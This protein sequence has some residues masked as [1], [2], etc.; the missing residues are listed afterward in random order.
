MTGP[1]R[2]TARARL[3]LDSRRPLRLDGR[4]QIFL[5][6]SGVVDVFARTSG[7]GR[8]HLFRVADGE[9]LLG[10]P[11][12]DAL[13]VLGVGSQTGKVQV[14]DRAQFDDAGS[15][16]VWLRRLQA[17]A[18]GQPAPAIDRDLASDAAWRAVDRA[19]A[20]AMSRIHERLAR[21]DARENER[22]RRRADAATDQNQRLFA[23]LARIIAPER[24][25]GVADTVSGDLLFG[26]CRIVGEAL[27]VVMAPAGGDTDFRGVAEIARASRVRVRKTLLRSGWRDQDVGPLVAW[28]G[29]ERRPV[30]ILPTARGCDLVDPAN[31][32]RQPIDDA[33][34]LN[35]SAE[36]AAFYRPLPAGPLSGIGLML[37]TAAPIR[38]DLIR[39]P[40]AAMGLALLA[41]GPPLVTAVLVDEAIPRADVGALVFCA[42]A[43][44]AAAIGA[45][46]FQAIQGVAILRLST[47]ADRMLQAA[48]IDR[49][50]R[51]PASF[52]KRF[53]AGDLTDRVL[54]VDEIRRMLTGRA[55]GGLLAGIFCLFGIALMFVFEARLAAVAAGLILVQGAVI[56]AVSARRLRLERRYFDLHG[57]THGL[58]LQIL[59]GVGKLRVADAITR[60]L[61]NWVR[62]F[63][64][65][66]TQFIAS[67]RA[68]NGLA[69]FEATYP[70]AA[71]LTVFALAGPGGEHGADPGRFLAFFAAFGQ[72]LSAMAALGAAV[73]ETLMAAPVFDRLR[74]ILAEPVEASEGLET[75]GEIRGEVELVHV[76]FRYAQTGA[77]ILDRMALHVNAGE[78]VALVGPSGGGKSTI[79]RLLLGF[80]R[81]HSGAIL[82]DGRPIDTLD[83]SALRRQIGVV[84][85]DGK[86]TSGSLYENI[87]GASEIPIEQAWEAARHAGL[88]A[89]IE[90]MPMG[91]HTVVT[92]GASTLSGGQRQRLMIA[93][94]LVHRPRLLLFDEATSALDNRLQ[95]VVSASIAGLK[96]TRIVIAHRLSTVRSAD[97]I[98]VVAAG[99]VVQAGDY[100]SLRQEPGLFADLARRQLV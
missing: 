4:T 44:A 32:M 31:G 51:L 58:V 23:R 94:A 67:Q 78:F 56:V 33:M 65:Q 86:L 26:A 36:A 89:D 27:G 61:A 70:I 8:T 50:L 64:A 76:T 12:I 77:P 54:G 34:A 73:G 81:A 99:A 25:S 75:L 6:L 22:L 46:A 66:K 28:L 3:D 92:E 83:L 79:L 14:I 100:E 24:T 45:A 52:F 40:M 49:L 15:V 98:Y 18:G 7:A 29:E 5:V 62:L 93:R 11:A 41:L 21:A 48:V 74:P 95:A 53:S 1:A 85:Q 20:A 17:A 19:Q 43:L 59:T 72:A 68:A 13:E 60:A 16:E 39:V 84:L 38:A 80:E 97:R 88:A 91:M 10:L 55:I 87:C 37:W 82:I 96:V 69:V 90:A 47:A 63:A 9:I 42:L 30:A 71:S 35:L 57:K 2:E